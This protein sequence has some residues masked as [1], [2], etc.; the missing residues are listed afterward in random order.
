MGEAS[1]ML[2][3]Q[4]VVSAGWSRSRQRARDVRR[5]FEAL[6]PFY[7]K[8]GQILSTRPDIVSDDMIA[9]LQN[10]HDRVSVQPFDVFRPV[11]E[12]ELGTGW[13]RNFSEIDVDRPLG[14]ASLAQVY[15]VRLRNG[16]PAVVKVQR[17]GI[18]SLM[19]A[20]MALLHRVARLVAR[21]AP[22][23]NAVVD[24][25][26]MMG[27]VF[28]VMRAELDLTVEAQNMEKARR[29]IGSFKYLNIPDVLHVGPRVMIQ[30]RAPGCSIRDADP[31][32]FSDAD[33]QGI[34]RD[35]MAY[36]YHSYFAEKFFHADPH[37]GN[38][39]VQPGEQA[40]L[41]DWGMVGRLDRRTGMAIMLVLLNLA[42]N[43]G[44][45][46]ARAWMEFGHPTAWADIPS[47]LHDMEALVPR[48]VG[49]SLE[50]LDFG[51][52]LTRVLKSSTKRGIRTNPMIAVL[53][54]S[55]ANLE[56]CVRLLT[57]ELS[58]TSTFQDEL[59]GIMQ[60]VA[61]ELVSAERIARST[62]ESALA[63]EGFLEEARS[64]LKDLANRQFTVEVNQSIR[65]DAPRQV[66]KYVALAAIAMALR[67]A[68]RSTS[69]VQR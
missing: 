18:D 49:A 51:I 29:A 25:P 54:K 34:G 45:G 7:V 31:A 12:A 47:F 43:D 38:L 65:P 56:G 3:R 39:F 37:P 26:A 28:D 48:I 33:R 21:T 36:M 16:Q 50:D 2:G 27:V 23:F 42:M 68:W 55:F 61:G 19:R 14:A 5:T 13:E 8:L 60:K 32:A 4:D 59:P 52:T 22:R 20:D 67:R 30:S 62:L 9:E 69:S 53:G 1:R 41:L 57:P 35:L 58:I 17:P 64:F 24:V 40:Y 15:A 66:P 10:L 44:R 6:G 11:L 63:A 46:M